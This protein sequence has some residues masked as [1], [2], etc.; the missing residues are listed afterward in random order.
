MT[1]SSTRRLSEV[2]RV[3]VQPSGIA[4]T[5]WLPVAFWLRK[6]GLSFDGWQ[7]GAATLILGKRADGLYACTVSGAFLSIPRQVG[8]TFMVGAMVFALC[9]LHPGLTVVWTAHR[10]KTAAETYK[11]MKGMSRRKAIS[12][13]VD[14]TPKNNDEW[15]VFF[16]NGS[17]ILFGAR[18]NGFGRGFAELDVLVF[19]EAQILGEKALDDMIPA[20]NA[21]KQLAGGLPIFMGTPPRPEDQCEV[22][23]QARDEALSGDSDDILWIEFGPRTPVDTSAWPAGYVD[24][25]AFAEAN[26]SYP[27]RTS[28]AALLRMAKRLSRASLSR[29][30]LG[31]YDARRA[32]AKS[33][34]SDARWRE[35]RVSE[36]P[37]GTPT[38]GVRFNYEGTRV[39]LA[40]AA[41]DGDV[42]HV[43]VIEERATDDGVGWL[44]DW[45]SERWR[46]CSGIV[47]D[48]KSGAGELVAALIKGG[49]SK[50]RVISPT[51]A[52]FITAHAQFLES[53][54]AGTLSHFDQAELNAAV[55]SAGKRV[56]DKVGGGWGW[57]AIAGGNVLP[58]EAA[59]LAAWGA[60]QSAKPSASPDTHS[61]A[62]VGG[63]KW[64]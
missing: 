4:T 59:T 18:E 42:V 11:S 1:A 53:V 34:I 14:K 31:Q 62:Y 24:F 8:K 54:K 60:R 52:Q 40:V 47:V 57:Q 30:G 9:L 10:T 46:D 5:G 15:G 56:I 61:K 43:E 33:V 51:P 45:L 37:S 64:R 23:L 32:S 21:S 39:A 17:R 55:K 3:V 38:Y 13:Y 22:W 49:V 63:M 2:A 58:L 7:E 41:L 6:L 36:A 50:R 26:P 16:A 25:D 20:M 28:R 48:G 44:K 19:D 27:L 12:P 29:E 35:L